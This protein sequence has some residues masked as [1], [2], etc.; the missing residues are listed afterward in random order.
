LRHFDWDGRT[1]ADVSLP[2]LAA[3]TKIIATGD[4]KFLYSV[5]RYSQPPTMMVFD[6]QANQI[7]RTDL[8]ARLAVSFDDI[9]EHSE[10]AIARDGTKIP[11]IILM[12]KGTVLNGKNPTILTGYG[13]YGLRI[14]PDMNIFLRPMFDRGAIFASAAVRGGGEYGEPWHQ[15]G[16]LALQKNGGE[17]SVGDG[18]R[19]PGFISGEQNGGPRYG[20]R[21]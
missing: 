1:L 18:G 19:E 14:P 21:I 15:A 4:G 3:V 6:P 20:H 13:S 17:T 8:S 2:P 11:V 10:F 9:E 16:A 12:R 7:G 5:T